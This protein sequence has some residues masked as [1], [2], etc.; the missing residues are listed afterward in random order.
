MLVGWIVCRNTRIKGLLQ[1]VFDVLGMNWLHFWIEILVCDIF[2]SCAKFVAY[3]SGIFWY[4]YIAN[5]SIFVFYTSQKLD[6]QY[7]ISPVGEYSMKRD[8]LW[9]NWCH[10]ELHIIFFGNILKWSTFAKF[11]ITYVFIRYSSIHNI[12]FFTGRC[13]MWNDMCNVRCAND[14]SVVLVITRM[15]I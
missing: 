10:W 8:V 6:L 11:T 3:D 5:W 7:L 15:F 1:F 14:V 12:Y 9:M 2:N 4:D 13:A